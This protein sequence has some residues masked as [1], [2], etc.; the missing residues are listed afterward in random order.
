[1][2]DPMKREIERAIHDAEHPSGMS[3]HDGMARISSATL[4][5]LVAEH[6][7]MRDSVEAKADRIDRL[8]E[9]VE[10]LVAQR[11][12]LQQTLHDEL[13]GNLRLRDLGG[14]RPD[15]PMLTF[16]ERI[17][18]ERDALLAA[19]KA[20]L[21]QFNYHTITGLVH[22]ESAAIAKARAAIKAA[23]EGE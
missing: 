14:A 18:A 22:D 4:R 11:D 21:E 17:I 9:M 13:A 1:M 10:R 3:T 16:L 19:L 8:G 23:E 15:E 12:A 2:T 7:A 5:R 20:M 6:E